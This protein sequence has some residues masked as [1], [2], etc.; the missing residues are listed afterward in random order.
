MSHLGGSL[1]SQIKNISKNR[2]LPKSSKLLPLYVFLDGDEIIRISGKLR[3]ALIYFQKRHSVALLSKHPFTE[4]IIRNKHIRLHIRCQEISLQERYWPIVCKVYKENCAKIYKCMKKNIIHY[5]FI[6]YK[7]LR[8]GH[9]PRICNGSV[10]CDSSNA[11]PA[12][13][14]LESWLRRFLTRK[15]ACSKIIKI[16]FMHF[17]MLMKTIHL[18]LTTD[19][20]IKAFLN[21]LR[22]FIARRGLCRKIF[23]DNETTFIGAGNKLHELG[24]LLKN[25]E[26]N[27]KMSSA[28][29]KYSIEWHLNSLHTPYF[30]ELW[31][32]AIKST[33]HC[34]VSLMNKN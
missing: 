1:F 16:L 18:E 14:Y 28:L 33:K 5:K 31:E 10:I 15:R 2:L 23:S 19:L 11:V 26:H 4:I 21:Y 24:V 13:F 20:S 29:R 17:N 7:V 8:Q 6:K 3:N 25:K 30:D 12:I 27:T 22:E 32:S 34:N 9:D